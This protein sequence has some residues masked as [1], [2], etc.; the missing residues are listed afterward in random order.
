MPV[1]RIPLAG[2]ITQRGYVPNDD[3][4][5]DQL[6][7]GVVPDI[8]DNHVTGK[9]TIY[10]RKQTSW[11][12]DSAAAAGN[13]GRAIWSSPSTSAVVAAFGTTTST[14]YSG[15]TNCGTLTTNHMA[16]HITETVIGG[17][18]FYLITAG[19][20][21][22]ATSGWFLAS[23]A[24]A[25][26]AYVGDTH[27]NTTVDNI[28]STAGMYA[29]QAI[30]GTG[31]P[32][33]TRIASVTSGT[34]ILL[35]TAA[36]A[37]AGGVSLTKTRIAKIIDADFPTGIVGQF[38]EMNG[39]VHIATQ[40]KIYSSDLNTLT[41]WTANSFLSTDRSTDDGVGLA[42]VGELIYAFGTSLIEA[43]YHAGNVSG[44][45][46]ARAS[47]SYPVGASIDAAYGRT[48]V[49]DVSGVLAWIE[50]GRFATVYMMAGDAPKK[51]STSAI[52]AAL[53]ST[54]VHTISAFNA[55]GQK[56]IFISTAAPRNF[57]YFVDVGL[58]FEL[59]F[60]SVNDAFLIS[61]SNAAPGGSD[62]KVKAVASLANTDGCT[63]TLS[64][65]AFTN[66]ASIIRS[67]KV[68]HGTGKRKFIKS[69]RLVGDDA[70][71]GTVTLAKCDDDS[72]SF[73]TLGTFTL[74]DHDKVIWRC[75]SYK[76]GRSYR[77]T[78]STAANFRWEAL[79]IEYEV[80][81]S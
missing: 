31:I 24:I 32:A 63:Y 4:T 79:E 41:G 9:R 36:T 20:S 57:A 10:C 78:H 55:W 80:G 54:T 68:D 81:T 76:G 12:A 27:S 2:N 77:L 14:I 70:S 47:R 25:Q 74:S 48:W 59:D 61:S 15:T 17:V 22:S 73:T 33:N 71:S 5:T 28:A 75:G 60:G 69:I 56:I 49:T 45:V 52:S 18:T 19:S 67:S 34:A 16:R 53:T 42:R 37:T 11:D 58:W 38:V 6:F 40:T 26:T 30:S 39:F 35:D 8:Y 3:T 46:L 64:A 43:F 23:D 1:D 65:T 50:M 72:G 21:I 29:G 13:V 51:I 44:S 62:G 66:I 7:F